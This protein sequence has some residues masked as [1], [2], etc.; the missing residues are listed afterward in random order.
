[1][2][3]KNKVMLAAAIGAVA[4]LI[5]SSVVRCAVSHAPEE[6]AGQTASREASQTQETEKE[7]EPAASDAGSGDIMEVLQSH[8]WQA[9]GDSG[10]TITFKDG[11]FVESDGK[12]SY[13]TAF[14]VTGSGE[15]SLD[16]KLTRDGSSSQISTTIVLEGGEGSYTV[17]CDGFKSSTKYVQAAAS[18]SPVAVSG[19]ADKYTDLIDGKTDALASAVAE[20]CRDHV[21][22]AT[23]ATF[24]GEVYLDTNTG[25]V[26]A[27]FHCDDT[28][29]TILSVTYAGGEFTVSG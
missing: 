4:I 24:D 29:A 20:Y 11:M 26:T 14:D 7:A 10:K 27:T 5:A 21:P 15:S 16:V 8:A 13:V 23:K 1:M 25:R 2:E 18:K 22:T 28:A 12:N 6:D 17:R 9:D 19:L 3:R